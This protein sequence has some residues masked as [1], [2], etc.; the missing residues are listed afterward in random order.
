MYRFSYFKYLFVCRI[1]SIYPRGKY[2]GL[3]GGSGCEC[4]RGWLVLGREAAMLVCCHDLAW[5][6]LLGAGASGAETG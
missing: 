6:E 2:V 1:M 3:N 4:R 5:A